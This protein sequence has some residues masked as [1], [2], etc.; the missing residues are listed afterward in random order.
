MLSHSSA[1]YSLRVSSS[2]TARDFHSSYSSART[3]AKALL[4]TS[5]RTGRVG[6]PGTGRGPP[7]MKLSYFSTPCLRRSSNNEPQAVCCTCSQADITFK[8]W[9]L[10]RASTSFRSKAAKAAPPTTCPATVFGRIAA[11]F[12]SLSCRVSSCLRKSL[13]KSVYGTVGKL[14]SFSSSIVGWT[15][16]TQFRWSKNF[17]KLSLTSR[18]ARDR[19]ASTPASGFALSACSKYSSELMGFPDSS[20]SCSMKSRKHQIRAGLLVSWPF[21]SMCSAR[22]QTNERALKRPSFN[23]PFVLSTKMD[24]SSMHNDI[25]LQS[26]VRSESVLPKPSQ[27]RYSIV[28]PSGPAVEPHIHKP[29]VHACVVLPTEKSFSPRCMRPS[30]RFRR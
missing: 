1:Q 13:R 22:W 21:S 19:S 16:V 7:A 10:F 3:A 18:A 23:T 15:N 8:A 20:S 25:S 11:S 17:S 30:K 4:S 9:L 6:E 24:E 28:D 27:S 29:C 2:P 14:R 5:S 26:R 12:C